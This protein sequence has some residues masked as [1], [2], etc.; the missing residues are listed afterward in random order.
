MRSH[1]KEG[2]VIT[3]ADFDILKQEVEDKFNSSQF[4]LGKTVFFDNNVGISRLSFRKDYPTNKIVKSLKEAE[5]FISKNKPSAYIYFGYGS[6]LVTSKILNKTNFQ[7]NLDSTIYQLNQMIDFIEN[8][9]IKTVNPK[10]ITF[11]SSNEELPVEMEER[12]Q[13]MLKS[14]DMETFNL[15]WKILFEYDYLKSLDKFFLIIAKA[16]K[17]SYAYRKKTRSIEQK[18]NYIK[19][20]FSNCKF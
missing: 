3:Q 4:E 8:T 15:G 7:Y 1:Y 16:N 5:I 20:Q 11:K 6:N 12:I 18:L 9:K 17:K 10:N 19:E 2:D 14:S 13:T